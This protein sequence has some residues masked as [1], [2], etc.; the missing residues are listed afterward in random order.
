MTLLGTFPVAIAAG[1]V[2]VAGV[3]GNVIDLQAD[4]GPHT[5]FDLLTSTASVTVR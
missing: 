5:A 1:P 2:R 3:N 4:T